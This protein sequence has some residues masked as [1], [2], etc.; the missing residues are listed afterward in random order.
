M[1]LRRAIDM[2]V[3]G[4]GARAHMPAERTCGRWRSA[5]LALSDLRAAV[6]IAG[7]TRLC[8]HSDLTSKNTL[9]LGNAVVKATTDDGQSQNLCV[10]GVWTQSGKEAEGTVKLVFEYGL[11][12]AE[13]RLRSAKTYGENKGVDMDFLP[14]L[15]QKGSLAV[16]GVHAVGTMQDHAQRKEARLLE[17]EFVKRGA[18]AGT[19]V[20]VYS[21]FCW[22]HKSYN[23]TIGCSQ[24]EQTY[25]ETMLGKTSD[26]YEF[27]A[28]DLV[29][30][31]LY[32][33]LLQGVRPPKR[34]L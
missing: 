25:L 16:H 21:G 7:A 28:S 32:E 3:P 26:F 8:L 18:S 12:A 1:L 33:T 17:A 19:V 11:D 20:P 29:D 15:F 34:R 23:F 4:L 22:G 30:G 13:E 14:N 5:L 2:M 6:G 24:G 27:Y 10:G 9:S 31:L